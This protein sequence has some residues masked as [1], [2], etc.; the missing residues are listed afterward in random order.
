VIAL[1]KM[2]SPLYPFLIELFENNL[3]IKNDLRYE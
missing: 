1:L 3:S 2:G